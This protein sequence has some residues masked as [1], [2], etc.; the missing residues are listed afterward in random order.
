MVI[1]YRRFGTT[2]QSYLQGSLEDGND[3]AI[4]DNSLQNLVFCGPFILV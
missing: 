3:A 2:Y 1:P 4:S